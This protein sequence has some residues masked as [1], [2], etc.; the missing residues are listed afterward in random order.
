M[1]RTSQHI[2]MATLLFL[3]MVLLSLHRAVAQDTFEPE[4][5]YQSDPA[6]VEAQ[7]SLAATEKKMGQGHP[8]VAACLDNLATLYVNVNN[9]INDPGSYIKSESDIARRKRLR[10]AE[11]FY[12][13]ALEIRDSTFRVDLTC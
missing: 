7:A 10:Q 9:V 12:K 8:Y 13:R 2:A 3:S 6:L 5:G 1:L 4:A 11:R